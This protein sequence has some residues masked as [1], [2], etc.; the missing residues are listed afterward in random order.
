M[1][2]RPMTD[3][4]AR[5]VLTVHFQT[6]ILALILTAAATAATVLLSVAFLTY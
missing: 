4:E 3:T 6:A 1:N 5:R 2:R